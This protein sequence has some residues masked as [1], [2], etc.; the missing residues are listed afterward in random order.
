[1]KYDLNQHSVNV[2]PFNT[3]I[4]CALCG[5]TM[6]QRYKDGMVLMAILAPCLT[7]AVAPVMPKKRWN[8]SNPI[9][10][11]CLCA[12]ILSVECFLPVIL[13]EERKGYNS[14]CSDNK[15]YSLSVFDPVILYEP[16][17]DH[18]CFSEVCHNIQYIRQ[19]L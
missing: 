11:N 19:S 7:V 18:N 4:I 12:G 2:I 10:G 6:F 3:M 14:L 15:F 13:Q 8:I 9:L 16:R 1:M 5:L 17:K